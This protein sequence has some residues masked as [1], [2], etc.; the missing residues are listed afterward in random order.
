MVIVCILSH[1]KSNCPAGEHKKNLPEI[2][3]RFFFGSLLC[4]YIPAGLPTRVMAQRKPRSFRAACSSRN[5]RVPGLS[6]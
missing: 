6:Q 3:G 2:P 4:S 1:C 5:L